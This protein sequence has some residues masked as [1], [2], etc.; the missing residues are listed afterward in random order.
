MKESA[1]IGI[2]RL[3]SGSTSQAELSSSVVQ[4]I[5]AHIDAQNDRIEVLEGQLEAAESLME[6]NDD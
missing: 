2:L 3:W 1:A 4:Q 5:I 6:F